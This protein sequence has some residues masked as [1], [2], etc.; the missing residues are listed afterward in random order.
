MTLLIWYCILFVLT[1]GIW[2]LIFIISND[3]DRVYS[4]S[5]YYVFVTE[6]RQI[7]F[8]LALSVLC[9]ASFI[10]GMIL[11]ILF[12]KGKEIRPPKWL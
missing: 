9:P 5:D 8:K 4:Q 11:L 10:V 2:R 3:D 7:L 12:I 6:W 1:W